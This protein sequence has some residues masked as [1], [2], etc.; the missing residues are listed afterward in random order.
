MYLY[1][2]KS[3]RLPKVFKET[4]K[5]DLYNINTMIIINHFQLLS[6]DIDDCQNRFQA[7]FF[8]FILFSIP[9]SMKIKN[10]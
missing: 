5:R 9:Q 8:K 4:F 3:I 7:L 2:R 10:L 1:F 6:K